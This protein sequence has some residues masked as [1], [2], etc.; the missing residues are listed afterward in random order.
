MG[1]RRRFLQFS[2]AYERRHDLLMV[3]QVMAK[4]RAFPERRELFCA[5]SFKLCDALLGALEAQTV[6]FAFTQ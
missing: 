2:L 6:F 1:V 3:S 4:H 5:V